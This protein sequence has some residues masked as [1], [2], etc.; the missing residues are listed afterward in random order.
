MTKE[1]KWKK[2]LK[3][4]LSLLC[5]VRIITKPNEKNRRQT[6]KLSGKVHFYYIKNNKWNNAKIRKDIFLH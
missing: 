2:K 5:I 4:A 6:V 3:K 1:S